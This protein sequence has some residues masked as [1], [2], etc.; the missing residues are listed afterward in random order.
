MT[1]TL[2]ATRADD[3]TPLR[4]GVVAGPLFVLT[5]AAQLA[6]RDDFDLTR[7]PISLLSVG[8]YG[9]VQIANFVVTGALYVAGA[10]GIARTT[11]AKWAAR[12]LAL[13]GGSLVWAGIFVADDLGADPTLHG[14]LHEIAPL[15]SFVGLFVA[16]IALGRRFRGQDRRGWAYTSY[17]VAVS[18]ML[19][20][21]AMN[22]EWYSLVLALSGAVGWLY[23]SA[24]TARLAQ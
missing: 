6:L 2:T 13:F 16:A 3:A 11:D 24:A 9:A 17:A 20:D 10:V 7:E 21:L 19:P 12:M 23:A 18:L 22:Q 14:T 1:A 8:P 5:A 4:C 15:F